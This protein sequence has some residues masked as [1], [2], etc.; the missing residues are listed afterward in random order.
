MHAMAL[1]LVDMRIVAPLR[2]KT[3]GP[4]RNQSHTPHVSRPWVTNQEPARQTLAKGHPHFCRQPRKAKRMCRRQAHRSGPGSSS[5]TRQLSED[6][7]SSTT[8]CDQAP[9]G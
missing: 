8:W 9:F 3:R 2:S 5:A 7:S 6:F 1:T 4:Q